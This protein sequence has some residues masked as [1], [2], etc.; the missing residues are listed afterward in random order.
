MR[1]KFGL[2]QSK[3]HPEPVAKIKIALF[4][5]CLENE[6]VIYPSYASP[7]QFVLRIFVSKNVFEVQAVFS[8]PQNKRV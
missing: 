2:D 7:K 3:K 6:F 8:P 1:K 5:F 4:V